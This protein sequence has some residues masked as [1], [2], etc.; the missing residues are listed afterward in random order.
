MRFTVRVPDD[1]GET[2]KSV[3]DNVSACVTEALREKIERDRRR[4]P[5]KR[6]LEG[7]EDYDG[8]GTSE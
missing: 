3:T 2:V 4:T 1:I 7:I 8:P 6:I 5:R